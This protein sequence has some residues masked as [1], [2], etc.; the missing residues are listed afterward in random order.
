M[1]DEVAD[2]MDAP[3]EIR[4]LDVDAILAEEASTNEEKAEQATSEATENNPSLYIDTYKSSFIVKGDTKQYKDELGKKGLGGIWHRQ[5]QGW[6]FP[7]SRREELDGWVSD[8][9]GVTTKQDKKADSLSDLIQDNLAN[10]NDN[11]SL[12]SLVAQHNDISTGEVTDAQMKEAQEIVELAL[13]KEAQA[14]VREGANPKDTYDK[15]VNLYK[16]QPNLTVRSSTS[17]KNQAYSTPAPLAYLASNLA[18]IKEDSTVYEPTAGNGMLLIGASQENAVVN[19]LNDL[20]VEQLREQGYKVTQKDATSFVPNEKVDS[21]IMNPPF[22]KL[23]QIVE[24]D[25]IN[26]QTLV[27]VN[28]VNGLN[29]ATYILGSVNSRGSYLC[30]AL[31]GSGNCINTN[32]KPLCLGHHANNQCFEFISYNALTQSANWELDG[33][34]TA[35]GVFWVDGNLIVG[36]GTN[37]STILVTGNLTTSGLLRQYAVNFGAKEDICE[38]SRVALD[39]L[40]RRRRIDQQYG[41]RPSGVGLDRFSDKELRTFPYISISLYLAA[42]IIAEHSGIKH[43]YVMV[44]PKLARSLSLFGIKMTRI[45]PDI[46]YHGI[47]A[48]YHIT[49]ERFQ[50]YLPLLY[51]P[52]FELIKQNVQAS[53]GRLAQASTNPNSYPAPLP[54]QS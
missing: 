43:A 26:N 14:I 13:V 7:P 44:E 9:T 15:L 1:T 37:T 34:A 20:R 8:K 24:Y 3:R 39:G 2:T 52:L 28:N 47:R 35:P 38:V 16:N 41:A 48:A 42:S 32:A 36:S 46:D 4:A 27:T 6:M 22:G 49:I 23:D 18:G 50:S 54:L 29:N 53:M 12:K 25:V 33:T 10:I 31:D 21:A 45:G 40:F 19:E 30:E 5:Q 17:M 51:Q 11:R